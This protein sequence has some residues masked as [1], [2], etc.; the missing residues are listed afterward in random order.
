VE[1][2]GHTCA[3]PDDCRRRGNTGDGTGAGDAGPASGT[4]GAD[5]DKDDLTG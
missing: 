1:T 5:G 2:T 4:T 3:Q